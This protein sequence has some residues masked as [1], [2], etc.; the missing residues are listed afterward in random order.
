[1]D[2]ETDTSMIDPTSLFPTTK[3]S[4][5]SIPLEEK[6]KDISPVSPSPT[7]KEE[8]EDTIMRTTQVVEQL[9][10]PTQKEEIATKATN[11][12]CETE[13]LPKDTPVEKVSAPLP[14]KHS[15]YSYDVNTKNL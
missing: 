11:S 5:R 10:E 13:G 6:P 4:T 14:S 2:N 7:I 15:N 1:M 9:E 8:R 3:M 12:D